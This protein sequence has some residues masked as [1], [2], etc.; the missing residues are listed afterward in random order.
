MNLAFEDPAYILLRQQMNAWIRYGHQL[1]VFRLLM[2]YVINKAN[3]RDSDT[4]RSDAREA[5]LERVVDPA[6]KAQLATLQQR[7]LTIA[8]KHLITG[9]PIL[10]LAMLFAAIALVC[11]GAGLGIGQLLR[12]AA[13]KVLVGPLNRRH[14]EE[15]AFMAMA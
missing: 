15:E 6:V 3:R 9:S 13:N 7:A 1:T 2:T 10:W 8:V 14:I 11:H 4:S 12:A 5:A